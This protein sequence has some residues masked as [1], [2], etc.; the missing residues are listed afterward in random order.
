M[1][2]LL[3]AYES[4]ALYYWCNSAGDIRMPGDGERSILHRPEELPDAYRQLYD[5]YQTET[6]EGH[7]HVVEYAGRPGMLLAALYDKSYFRDVCQEQA[8]IADQEFTPSLD[9]FLMDVAYRRLLITVEAMEKDEELAGC[10]VLVGKNTDPDGHEV[11]LFIPTEKAGSIDDIEKAFYRHLYT[12]REEA[13][14]AKIMKTL[15]S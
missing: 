2:S 11:C 3:T 4:R 14:V 7:R 8:G 1:K 12:K 9:D 6:G 5:R 15:L 10:T 13:I